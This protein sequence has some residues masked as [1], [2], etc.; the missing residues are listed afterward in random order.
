M[1]REKKGR[2]LTD[3]DDV[4]NTEKLLEKW[5]KDASLNRPWSLTFTRPKTDGLKEA[6]K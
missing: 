1:P 2:W 5:N 4:I 3:L 6:Q